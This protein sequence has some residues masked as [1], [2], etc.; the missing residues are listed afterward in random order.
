MA[1][2]PVKEIHLFDGDKLGQHNAFRSPG[3]PSIETLKS[4]PQKASHYRD[5]YSEMR[6]NIFAHGYVDESLVDSLRAMDFVF[7]AVD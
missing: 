3:A 6:R 7:I 5:I 1:K 4:A 2:T